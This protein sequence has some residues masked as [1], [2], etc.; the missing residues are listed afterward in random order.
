MF[1]R[2]DM[3]CVFRHR[4][5]ENAAR[6]VERAVPRSRASILR[7]EGDLCKYIGLRKEQMAAPAIAWDA[8]SMGSSGIK[9]TK[10]SLGACRP[11][12]D[13]D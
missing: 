4:C 11:C 3:R 13:R 7:E 2:R 8:S 6:A 9:K 10:W 5:K 1:Y 12:F